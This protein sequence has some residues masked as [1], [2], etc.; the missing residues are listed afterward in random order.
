MSVELIGIGAVGVALSGVILTGNRG[1]R[2]DMRQD[3]AQLE[4]RLRDDIKQLWAI[5]WRGWSIAKPSSKGCWKDCARPSA[6]GPLPA[7]GR[8]RP[9]KT[10]MLTRRTLCT[11]LEL[12]WF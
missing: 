4:S 6:G 7:K 1:L 3:M 11:L 5:A 2:Q 10:P 12:C 8:E 9:Q